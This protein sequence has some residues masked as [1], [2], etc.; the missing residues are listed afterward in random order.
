MMSLQLYYLFHLNVILLNLSSF[1]PPFVTLSCLFSFIF[2]Q[3]YLKALTILYPVFQFI[4]H[5]IKSAC[6][7]FS[8]FGGLFAF[9][10]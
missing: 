1:F 9:L 6:I 3:Q 8:Y 4:F 2:K 10:S 7:I 5:F